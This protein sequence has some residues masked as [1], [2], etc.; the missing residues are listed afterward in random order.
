[1]NFG[2]LVVCRRRRNRR[3]RRVR[4]LRLRTADR[5]A[6]FEQYPNVYRSA[7]DGPGVS[8]GDV[9]RDLRR[10]DRRRDHLREGLRRRERRCRKV[11]DSACLLGFFGGVF[12]GGVNY[13]VLNINKKLAVMLRHGRILRVARD[14][15]HRHRPRLPAG[16]PVEALAARAAV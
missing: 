11:C 8:A 14:C 3:G 16:A 5:R 9:C 15:R 4:V 12:Y 10:D 2:R 13:G 1:M 6:E 7:V